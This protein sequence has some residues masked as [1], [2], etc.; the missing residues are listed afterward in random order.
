MCSYENSRCAQ[1]RRAYSAERNRDTLAGMTENKTSSASGY[2]L[3]ILLAL[4][5]VAVLLG[6]VVL[7]AGGTPAVLFI[8]GGVFLLAWLIIKASKN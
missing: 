7:A 1:R 5:I 3:A 2:Y 8:A 6:F 4:G